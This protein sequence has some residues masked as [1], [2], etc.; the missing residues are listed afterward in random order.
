MVL[1]DAIARSKVWKSKQVKRRKPEESDDM[2]ERAVYNAQM[3]QQELI[4]N[5]NYYA[6]WFELYD[7]IFFFW[8]NDLLTLTYARIL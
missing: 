5:L 2:L 3:A 7:N 1:Q 4:Q 8:L 6:E